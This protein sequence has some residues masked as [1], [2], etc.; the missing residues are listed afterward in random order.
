M[1]AGGIRG[2]GDGAKPGSEAGARVEDG[3]FQNLSP[4]ENQPPFV[5]CPLCSRQGGRHDIGAI[6]MPFFLAGSLPCFSDEETDT[7]RASLI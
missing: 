5:K 1:T 6:F 7:H 3:S 2:W 4:W